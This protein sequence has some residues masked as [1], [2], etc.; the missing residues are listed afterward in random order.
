MSMSGKSVIFR[1]TP[2]ERRQAE[3]LRDL[4]QE[5]EGGRVTLSDA[6]RRAVHLQLAREKA[7]VARKRRDMEA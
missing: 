4:L 5:R 2:A 7:A 6:Y 3:D 1:V